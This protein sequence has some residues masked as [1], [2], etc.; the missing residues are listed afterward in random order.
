[1]SMN[2][3]NGIKKDQMNSI[4]TRK[5]N[6][7]F[8]KNWFVCEMSDV[9]KITDI[10]F[11]SPIQDPVIASQKQSIINV[12]CT[13]STGIQFICE[14]QVAKTTGFEKSAQWYAAKA[15]VSQAPVIEF[16]A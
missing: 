15:Y 7:E 13:D 4:K 1:M 8:E 5:E 10:S 6:F 9:N 14:M 3:S 11:S 12:L 16:P 2:Y